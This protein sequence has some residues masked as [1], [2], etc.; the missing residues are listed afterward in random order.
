MKKGFKFILA[1]LFAV[2]SASQAL[3]QVNVNVQIRPPFTPFI[4]DYINP[5]KLQ[6][7]TVSVLNTSTS[8]VRVKFKFSLTNISKGISLS[9][10]E[11]SS[12]LK[13]YV[14]NP[15]EFRFVQLEDVSRLYGKITYTDF[16]VNG[17]DI[18]RAIAD[19]TVPDG[20]YEFCIEAFDYDAPGFSRPLGGGRPQGCGIFQVIYPDPPSDIRLNNQL[21]N[22]SFGGNIPQVNR[23]GSG[24]QLYQVN[25]TPPV[26]SLGSQYQYELYVFDEQ[27]LN[28]R[29]MSE[30]QMLSAF[31]VLPPYIRKTSMSPVFMIDQSEL[32]LDENKN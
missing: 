9:I 29:M 31:E 30:T 8:E 32:P 13:P 23:M 14:L 21:L 7:I 11:S 16:N 18:Q 28:P 3:A 24:V 22:Y 5:A 27:T 17:I 6:D 15:N 19:G 25:F 20:M 10:K 2:L 4:A 26:P 1:I 12:P